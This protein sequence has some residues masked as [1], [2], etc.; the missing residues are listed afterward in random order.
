MN[1]M[2]DNNDLVKV[3]DTLKAYH[4]ALTMDVDAFL[5]INAELERIWKALV[6][7]SNSPDYWTFQ[8]LLSELSNIVT[9]SKEF[10]SQAQN[11]LVQIEKEAVNN[12]KDPVDS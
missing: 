7:V 9:E 8:R 1:S 10:A 5:W 3:K 11:D 12:E 4:V 2:P 6:I